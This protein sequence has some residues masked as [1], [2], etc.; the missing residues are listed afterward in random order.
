[1][2][3]REDAVQ[4][5]VGN[6]KCRIGVLLRTEVHFATLLNE[7]IHTQE[8]YVTSEAGRWVL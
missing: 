3:L 8:R 7:V 2:Q 6:D 1:M 4:A 5:E